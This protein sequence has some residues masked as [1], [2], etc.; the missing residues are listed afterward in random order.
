MKYFRVFGSVCYILRDQEHLAK[1]DTKSEEGIIMG[2][3]NTSTAYRVY[4]LRTNTFKESINVKIDGSIVPYA[5]DADNVNL[6][7][8]P[9][10]D[11]ANVSIVSDELSE[12][13]TE[14]VSSS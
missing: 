6:F 3:S 14:C 13:D 10:K 1:F 9:F 4:N 7:S 12:S 2:Y 8:P 5:L 11:K